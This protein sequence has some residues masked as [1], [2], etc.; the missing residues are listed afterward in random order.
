L[1][2][3][4]ASGAAT[5]HHPVSRLL[6]QFTINVLME[7]TPTTQQIS[8]EKSAFSLYSCKMSNEYVAQPLCA[9]SLVTR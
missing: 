7:C 6:N 3:P 4:V 8:L 1:P 9:A 5:A 2:D